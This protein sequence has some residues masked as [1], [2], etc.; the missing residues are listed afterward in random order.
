MRDRRG[1][2]PCFPSYALRRYAKAIGA[3]APLE[4]LLITAALAE[5]WACRCP[6]TRPPRHVGCALP[7]WLL[8][9]RRSPRRAPLGA[10]RAVAVGAGGVVGYSGGGWPPHGRPK[11]APTTRRARHRR[12]GAGI[13]RRRPRPHFRRSTAAARWFAGVGDRCAG[14]RLPD[15]DRGS[16]STPT[17]RA[18]SASPAG[19]DDDG[20]AVIRMAAR[21]STSTSTG[22]RGDPRDAQVQYVFDNIK[23]GTAVPTPPILIVQAVHDY[24]IAVEDIDALPT[25]TRAVARR[26]LP[27]DAFN[28]HLL[29]HPLSAP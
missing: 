20:G 23:L 29:L 16:R 24:L 26:H 11:Y 10:H 4:F 12:R 22:A 18:D 9:S 7:T 27:R 5:G 8:H 14:A 2:V 6:T 3:L 28:E 15:L 1:G 21:T 17:K 25:P 19:G 13:A